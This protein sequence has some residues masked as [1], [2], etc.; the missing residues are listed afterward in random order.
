MNFPIHIEMISM[1]LPIFYFRGS[2]VEVSLFDVFL[3]LEVVFVL[4]NSADTDE[5]QQY[6]AFQLGFH[7]I[8]V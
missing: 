1:G 7:K 3:S 5:M 6:A 8:L 2:Q 4:A